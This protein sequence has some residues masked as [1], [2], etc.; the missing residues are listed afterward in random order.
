MKNDLKEKVITLRKKGN[1]YNEIISKL[2]VIIPK[3]TLSSWCRDIPLPHEYKAKLKKLNN[4]ALIKA[5]ICSIETSKIVRRK[6]LEM[7]HSENVPLIKTIKNKDVAKI[8]LAMLYLG[9]GRKD[10][11]RGSLL[12]GNSE[13][14][15]ISLFLYLLRLV[16]DIDEKKFRCTVQCRADQN[17]KTLEKL[18]SEITKIPLSQFYKTRI[19]PRTI[20][21]PTKKLDYKGVCCIDYFSSKVF[22]ELLE[23]PNVI[24]RGL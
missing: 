17:T 13:P 7:I 20:G 3:G 15:V 22:A 19:D 16:Y 12:F 14:M 11:K 4:E 8:A 5:R 9:E 2:K 24:K 6:E 23:L 18:W 10:R 21:K 1:T